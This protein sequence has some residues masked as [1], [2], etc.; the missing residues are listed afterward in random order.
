MDDW[1]SAD[2]D[3]YIAR[4]VAAATDL[5]RLAQVRAALRQRVADSPLCD[6]AGLAR[7]IEAAYRTLYDAC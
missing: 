6:A 4:A 7:H 1:V 5:G 3:G 2:T